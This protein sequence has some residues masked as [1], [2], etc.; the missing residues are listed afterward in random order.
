MQ[1]VYFVSRVGIILNRDT[2]TQSFYQVHQRKITCM[3]VDRP[4]RRVATG[5]T[6]KYP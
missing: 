2:R 1:V 6:G 3:A 4:K 5:E